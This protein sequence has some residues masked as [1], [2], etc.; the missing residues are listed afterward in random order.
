M[1]G[2]DVQTID[3]DKI[4]HAV[5]LRDGYVI[6]EHGLLKTKHALPQEFAEID[7][8]AQVVRTTLSKEIVH[9]SP[10][11]DEELDANAVAEHY[12][13]ADA[14]DDPITRAGDDDAAAFDGDYVRD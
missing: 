8:E 1:H 7:E 10:K 9:D 12:G 2:Y 14:S 6:V 4:G 13:L 5:D 3:G 11:L